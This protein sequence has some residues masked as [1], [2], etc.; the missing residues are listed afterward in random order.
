MSDNPDLERVCAKAAE[1]G[2]EVRQL[3]KRVFTVRG[4]RSK[5]LSRIMPWHIG[6][7]HA[8]GTLEEID[9]WLDRD[10]Q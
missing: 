3:S 6:T 5:L 10:R 2:Y 4:G 9:V 8:F 7:L 1:R